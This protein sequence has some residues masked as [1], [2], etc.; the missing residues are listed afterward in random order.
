MSLE[1]DLLPF[2]YEDNTMSYAHSKLECV[3]NCHD[4]YDEIEKYQKSIGQL[5]SLKVMEVDYNPK[6]DKRCV[7]KNFTSFFGCD[8]KYEEAHYGLTTTDPYGV[9]IRWLYVKELLQWK[10]HAGVLRNVKHR[11]VWAYLEQLDPETKVALVW[12]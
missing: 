11:A 3:S 7:P 9:P 8:D 4:L 6:K 2:D 1:L 12:S 5:N 10:N